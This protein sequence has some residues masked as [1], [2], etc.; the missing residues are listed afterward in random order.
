MQGTKVQPQKVPV[1]I[2]RGISF[3]Q[4]FFYVVGKCPDISQMNMKSFYFCT[5]EGKGA[6]LIGHGRLYGTL[7]YVA[8]VTQ[9]PEICRLSD[10]VTRQPWRSG[11]SEAIV[12]SL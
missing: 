6:L 8:S 4:V 2:P 7:R 1:Q 5:T 12:G 11:L 10:A 9:A 3:Y